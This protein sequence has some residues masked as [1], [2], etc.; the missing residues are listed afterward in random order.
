MIARPSAGGWVSLEARARALG[1]GSTA[2]P[3]GDGANAAHATKA[4]ATNAPATNSP[5]T[6]SHITKSPETKLPATKSP[7]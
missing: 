2:R 3:A 5:A 6:K 7:T 4:S 1:A